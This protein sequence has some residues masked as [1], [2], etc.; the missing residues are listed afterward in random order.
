MA[1]RT[2]SS[3]WKQFEKLA[4][5]YGRGAS[6]TKT[7]ETYVEALD[8]LGRRTNSSRIVDALATLFVQNY[9]GMED[10]EVEFVTSSDGDYPDWPTSFVPEPKKILVNPVGV[11]RFCRE[12]DESTK[13][14]KTP[15]ARENFLKYRYQA[16]LAELRKLPDKHLLFLQLLKEVANAREITHV[17]KKG[18]VIEHSEDDEY[19]V[20]VWAFRELEALFDQMN[21]L[22]LRSEYR[23]L[24]YDS[25]WIS[26]N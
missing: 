13:L 10:T 4:L 22:S 5:Q 18:G 15:A 26:G 16:Y 1:P 12:C 7:R 24:W 20:L 21:G 9:Q 23:I 2:L 3:A 11:F 8:D 14:L 17:E 25:D 19:T 6:S